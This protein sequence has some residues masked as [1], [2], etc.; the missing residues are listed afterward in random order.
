MIASEESFELLL[1]FLL[2]THGFDFTGYKRASLSR[3]MQ[4]RLDHLQITGFDEYLDYLQVH[5]EESAV[6]FDT[7]LIN[8]TAFFRDP[9]AWDVL[10]EKVIP[11]IIGDPESEEPLRVWS[12]G[13]ASGEEA[14]T[15]AMVLAEAMGEANFRRRVKIYAT[16]IDEDALQTARTGVY[17]LKDL[18]GIDPELGARYFEMQGAR[19]TFRSDLRRSVIFGR[20]DL[21]NHAPISRL[22]LLVSRN[23][24]MY[25]TTDMQSAILSRLHYALKES[26]YLFLGK[27]EMLLT[28]ANLFTP[29]DLRHRIFTPVPR[30]NV[31]D[32][33]LMMTRDRVEGPAGV[34]SRQFQ[35]RDL[36]IDAVP[37]AM[38]TVD[39][40]GNVVTIS[41]RARATFGLGPRDIGRRLHELEIS[42]RPAELRS[43]IEEAQTERRTVEVHNV[44]RA[45]PDG[46]SQYFDILITPLLGERGSLGTSLTFVD[47]TGQHALQSELQRNKQELETAYEE[48]QSTNEEL[49]T[50]NEELQSTVEELETTNEELQSA[51]EELETMNEELQSAN[52]ELQT[53]N[54]ELRSRSQELDRVNVFMESVLTS[55]STGLAVIDSDLRVQVWS[56]HAEELWGMRAGEVVGESFLRLDI[57][58]PVEEVA[59]LVRA[60]LVNGGRAESRRVDARNRRGRSLSVQVTCTP[61]VGP[62]GE[63][64]GVVMVMEEHQA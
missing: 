56:G 46:R 42:Y 33:L 58:L 39:A 25:F 17:A 7:I 35:L 20:H 13:C 23:T 10:R 55:M 34:G 38:V 64:S 32:R 44:E 27:A 57:G 12:A 61:L 30:A 36:A 28:H 50:T 47:V 51:N 16:D 18:E 49:E 31:R 60:C 3:R 6:L 54:L 59:T 11:T 29:L 14:Y 9:E 4:R 63:R 43:R 21:A 37:L 2:H 62:S 5:P 48:L 22:D 19:A 8:V 26:G 1:E 53:I 45:V 40:N 24:L 15:L 52:G 41:E